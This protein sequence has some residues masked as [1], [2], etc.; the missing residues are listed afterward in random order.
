MRD[1]Y[2]IRH[3]KVLF[4]DGQKRCIGQTDTPLDEEGRRQARDLAA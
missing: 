1:L 4:S 2:L 3:G